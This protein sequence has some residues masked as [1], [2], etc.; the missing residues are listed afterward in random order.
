MGM[1]LS[2]FVKKAVLGYKAMNSPK[3]EGIPQPEKKLQVVVFNPEPSKP[4]GFT[5]PV[6]VASQVK[7]G[8]TS[9]ESVQNISLSYPLI[10]SKPAEGQRVFASANIS[11]DPKGNKYIY[12]VVEPPRSE[13]VN[14]V[15]S[16]MKDLLEQKLDVD[17]SRL[18]KFEGMEFLHKATDDLL[19]YFK[20][21]SEEERSIIHY[22]IERDF[23]GFGRIEP[24]L[25]DPDIEDISCDGVGIP[26]FVFH[27][28]PKLSSV[29]TSV[30]FDDSDELDSLIIRL[31]QMCGKSISVATPLVDGS[32]PDGSRL[33]ATLATDIARRGSNFTIRKF[34][35]QPLTPIHMLNYNTLDVQVLAFLWMAVD[36]GK[37][38]LISGGTASGKTSLLNVLSLFIRPEKKICS[39]EDTPEL[40]LPHPHWVPSVARVTMSVEGA[41]KIGEVDLFDLLKES[42]RQR[43]DYIIVGE[44]RGKEAFVLFQEMA[45]GHASL[46]TIHAENMQKLIDRLTTAPISLPSG[47][48]SSLDLVCFLHSVRYK[49]RFVRRLNEV[50]EVVGLD[51][52]S[53]LP[54]TNQ[55]FKWNPFT[56]KFE[57]TNK[58]VL[59]KKISEGTGL[60]ERQ[61]KEELE[62]RMLVLDW[63]KE[64][65]LTDYRD[66]YSIFNMY[67]TYPER[68]IDTIKGD[69]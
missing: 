62:R 60:T 3:T 26:L 34:T 22:Y 45:T 68:V 5:I 9:E 14:A 44:V 17:F 64:R 66:V 54:V 1:M 67:Y 33:Q 18:K 36:Y 42:L 40:K 58:S 25:K 32:L 19:S 65:N 8:T 39:I 16:K 38:I 52:A 69:A 7:S 23:I 20:S 43:P 55:I 48:L 46:A 2:N 63:L 21:I 15:L 13:K 31:S 56:D 6:F 27:R 53:S 30:S 28:N 10:P 47:L 51:R 50:L 61:I 57:I 12:N 4:E 59:L 11:W 37:S 49:D 41:K 24:L 35:D 29:V